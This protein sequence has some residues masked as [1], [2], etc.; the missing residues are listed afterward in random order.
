MVCS[1]TL[2]DPVFD[3]LHMAAVTEDGWVE[4]LISAQRSGKSFRTNWT[5]EFSNN[6]T[7]NQTFRYLAHELYDFPNHQTLGSR[8]ARTIEQMHKQ[9][10]RQDEIYH[11]YKPTHAHNTRSGEW[12]KISVMNNL[13]RYWNF[14]PCYHTYSLNKS[15]GLFWVYGWIGTWVCSWTTSPMRWLS[16]WLG[17]VFSVYLRHAQIQFVNNAQSRF[18][19][20]STPCNEVQNLR[21][22]GDRAGRCTKPSPRLS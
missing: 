10:D 20:A 9:S 21:G 1:S 6:L 16:V 15:L 17:G 5:T 7:E 11:R 18:S 8:N 19:G 4:H 14:L 3:C 13:K 22:R 12:T 2:R